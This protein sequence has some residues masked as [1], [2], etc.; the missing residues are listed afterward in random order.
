MAMLGKLKTKDRMYKIGVCADD[1]CLLC[2]QDTE[3]CSHL[4]FQCPVSSIICQGVMRWIGVKKY[5]QENIY[6]SWKRWGRKFRRKK[7]QQVSYAVLAALVYYIWRCRNHALWK[8][9][10]R[11]P[12]LVIREIQNEVLRKVQTCID[13]KWSSEDRTWI[14]KLQL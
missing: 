7:Q 9:S 2:G 10:I 3:T 8:E 12:E 1:L 4:F 11:R 14:Q 6:T 13:M 5:P